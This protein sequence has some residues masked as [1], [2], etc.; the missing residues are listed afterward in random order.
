MAIAPAEYKPDE[1][2]PSVDE[3]KV[4]FQSIESLSQ[5]LSEK[6]HALL[7]L[8]AQT[9]PASVNELA[10]QDGEGKVKPIED[11]EDPWAVRADPS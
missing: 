2:K 9:Q 3:P 6:S 8:I 1:Y 7:A 10:L 11:V 5:V 4:W